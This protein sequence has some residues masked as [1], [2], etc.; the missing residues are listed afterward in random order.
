MLL[1]IATEMELDSLWWEWNY[2]YGVGGGGRLCRKPLPQDVC[3]NADSVPV[4]AVMLI[5]PL[6]T[7]RTT[8]VV[9]A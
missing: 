6:V 2:W 5:C 7:P 3:C 4:E 9:D 1:L 8:S